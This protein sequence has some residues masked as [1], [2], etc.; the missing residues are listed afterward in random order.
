MDFTRYAGDLFVI[1]SRGWGRRVVITCFAQGGINGR[2]IGTQRLFNL[3]V[4]RACRIPVQGFV[5]KL[6]GSPMLVG[7]SVWR[8]VILSHPAILRCQLFD[9]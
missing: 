4:S 6:P 8:N 2:R 3:R 9:H 7:F 1:L 5:R